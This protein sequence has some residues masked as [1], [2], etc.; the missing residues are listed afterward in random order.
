MELSRYIT[1]L[2]T[3]KYVT[4][5]EQDLS[6]ENLVCYHV[7][8][9][10]GEMWSDFLE[11][12]VAEALT[13]AKQEIEIANT[14][15]EE[16]K[17]KHV[18]QACNDLLNFFI[19]ANGLRHE[20]EST[21]VNPVDNH[22][23]YEKWDRDAEKLIKALAYYQEASI[24]DWITSCIWVRYQANDIYDVN[25][26]F[27][28]DYRGLFEDIGD[29]ALFSKGDVYRANLW[30]KLASVDWW[31]LNEEV[32]EELE[33]DEKK[34]KKEIRWWDNLRSTT[35][36][37]MDLSRDGIFH[38]QV[39]IA[40]N[41]VDVYDG[42]KVLLQ[43]YLNAW[44]SYEVG[45]EGQNGQ[46]IGEKA[47]ALLYEVE[48][49]INS[50]VNSADDRKKIRTEVLLA[51]IIKDQ[52]SYYQ[53]QT[54][55]ED[56][57]EIQKIIDENKSDLVLKLFASSEEDN[58]DPIKRYLNVTVI[59]DNEKAIRAMKLINAVTCCDR[60]LRILNSGVFTGTVAYYTSYET[61]GKMLPT[62][63][64]ADENIG[65]LSIMHVAYMNDPNE[66]KILAQWVIGDNDNK[67]RDI[68]NYP[69]VFIKCF[70]TRID[71]LPM[72]EMYGDHAEGC[73]IVFNMEELMKRNGIMF[74][75]YNVCYIR[76][77]NG[78]FSIAE[79]DNR[80][81]KKEGI[82]KLQENIE[83][84]QKIANEFKDDEQYIAALKA[85]MGRIQYLFKNADYSYECEKRI[86]YTA[87][88]GLDKRIKHTKAELP[89]LYM[90]SNMSLY[91]EEIILGPKFKDAYKR[92]PYLQER[93]DGM[94]KAI[95]DG[96]NIPIT[97]SEIDYK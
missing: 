39:I 63:A 73:C 54:M 60:I 81:I 24:D 2:T 4:P 21:C 90:T 53:L 76:K 5:L 61:L 93:L 64:D 70:T 44:A 58:I 29:V 80:G 51:E 15:S 77:K 40:P 92:I 86:V 23:L 79:D 85:I 88:D 19:A 26:S 74:P 84:L 17:Y 14:V 62:T 28:P 30:Y 91:L 71:D 13:H 69:Y 47:L 32:D 20:Y 11:E 59:A 97:Y 94:R 33:A 37:L 22:T 38:R 8:D 57:E 6:F 83:K 27:Q 55:A 96:R 95:G 89:M 12:N 25:D 35:D 66:G 78:S 10:Y 36:I 16:E 56:N 52:A 31:E 48:K 18:K 65:K 42:F 75:V 68:A 87:K 9:S 72:W 45:T 1:N 46:Q 3:N 41:I 7:K 50:S 82:I 34:I 67:G 43:D 49:D